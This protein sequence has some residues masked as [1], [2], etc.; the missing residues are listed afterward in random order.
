[1]LLM[2]QQQLAAITTLRCLLRGADN[3]DIVVAMDVANMV[4]CGLTDMR[5]DS[6]H[7]WQW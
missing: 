3:H 4:I 2:L 6:G 7:G 1:M 5:G